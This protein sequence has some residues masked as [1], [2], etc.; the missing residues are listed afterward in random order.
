M[1]GGELRKTVRKRLAN[2]PLLITDHEIDVRNLITLAYECFTNEEQTDHS[3]RTAEG[4]LIFTLLKP[5][6]IH[7]QDRSSASAYPVNLQCA[8]HLFDELKLPKNVT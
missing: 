1:S 6:T 7:Q 2:R 5:K 4:L 8:H 3:Q